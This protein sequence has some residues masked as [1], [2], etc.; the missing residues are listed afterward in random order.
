[1]DTKILIEL[2]GYL[3]SALVVVSMLMTSVLRLRIINLIGCL[4]FAGYALVIRSYPTAIMNLFL[5]GVNIYQIMR[6]NNTE[7]H[8]DV[9]EAGTGDGYLA[10]L[11][12]RCQSDIVRY[13]PRFSPDSLSGE[14]TRVFAV[15]CGREVV[16]VLIG[17]ERADALDVRLDYAT[18]E[19]RDCSVGAFLYG[20]LPSFGIT[21]LRCAEA[22]ENHLGYLNKM[23]YTREQDG[24]Y[25]KRLK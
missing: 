4:I 3:G 9:F 12:R 15:T 8:Y 11:L 7:K 23:G 24:A 14:G 1:M 16:G 25:R 20:K 19:F 10:F 5:V 22:G 17:E 21:S 13:F 2:I 6:L 18:P